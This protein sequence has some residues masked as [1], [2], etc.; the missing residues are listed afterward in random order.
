MGAFIR[1]A[2]KAY[3]QAERELSARL[4]DIDKTRHNTTYKNIEIKNESKR[5]TEITVGTSSINHLHVY[6]TR[7]IARINNKITPSKKTFYKTHVFTD[8]KE[9]FNAFRAQ[10][11]YSGGYRESKRNDVKSSNIYNDPELW[12]TDQQ[13]ILDLFL[14][15]ERIGKGKSIWELPNEDINMI[16][17]VILGISDW[18]LVPP[19]MIVD[20]LETL[21]TLYN[22][23]SDDGYSNVS[24]ELIVGIIQD[25]LKKQV[26]KTWK[27]RILKNLESIEERLK[28]QPSIRFTD[29]SLEEA[30]SIQYALGLYATGYIDEHVAIALDSLYTIADIDNDGYIINHKIM[31]III[32]RYQKRIAWKSEN[33]LLGELD[34]FMYD[35]RAG[36]IFYAA[37]VGWAISVNNIGGIGTRNHG[38]NKLNYNKIVTQSADEVNDSLKALGYT[39]APYKP[40]TIVD[41]IE[42]TEQ[43]K[44]VRVYDIVNTNQAGGWIMKADDIAGLTPQQIQNKFALP[45]KPTYVT[46]VILEEGTKLR[47]GIA[48]NLFGFDG[49]GIQFDLMGQYVGEFVN[50]RLLP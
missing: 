39:E 46:D 4:A 33:I 32:E 24:S 49:G 2:S 34:E 31:T 3:E 43:T 8:E 1:T 10:D 18:S 13:L 41:T 37:V 9:D 20:R 29:L 28:T 38:S 40:G 35:T 7:N 14:L 19:N 30:K 15:K 5:I 48:N 42:L 36:E 12:L 45:F 44:F 21:R 11:R 50:G 27:K 23:P 16:T 6:L 22:I 17:K 47:T 25:E 26:A